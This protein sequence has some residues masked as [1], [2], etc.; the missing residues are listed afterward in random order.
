MEPYS[1]WIATAVALAASGF[2]SVA[3]WALFSYS[4]SKLAERLEKLKD[5]ELKA[6]VESQLAERERLLFSATVFNT[7]ADVTLVVAITLAF[8]TGEE[9]ALGP[10]YALLTSILVVVVITGVIPNTVGK[11]HAEALI[12]KVLPGVVLL[13]RVFFFVTRPLAAL[14]H[15]IVRTVAQGDEKE[16]KAQEIVGEL[17][18]AALEGERE[19]I[20]EEDAAAMIESVIDFHDAEVREIMTPRTDMVLI[21]VKTPVEE[22]VRIA[23]EQGHSRIPVYEGTRDRIVGV[24]YQKD[25]LRALSAKDKD[26]PRDIRGLLRKPYFVPESKPI[27]DLLKEFRARKVHIAIVLDEY[28][29]TAGLVTIEDI[30]E[31]IIGEIDD[32]FDESEAEAP[33][34]RKVG[35]NAAEVDARLHID[36]FNEELKLEIP[37]D[38]DYE[39][40][41]GFLSTRMGRVPA[42]GETFVHDGVEFTILEADERRVDRVLVRV[43]RPTTAT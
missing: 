26:K 42:K 29:G 31:E 28:G 34:V 1:Y 30:I 5:A 21:E 11:F 6:R 10:L 36:E 27:G 23:L 24:L 32:E 13:D 8:L 40:V 16:R 12:P 2:C 38:G 19:G 25:L 22:A 9:R 17:R 18:D 39:T 7:L 4:P 41:G 43:N 33:P 35:D 14:E 20:L 3:Q 37:E 15:L